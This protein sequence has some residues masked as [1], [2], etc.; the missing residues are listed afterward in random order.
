MPPVSTGD[1]IAP[2][3]GESTTRAPPKP[4]GRI[5]L[6]RKSPPAPADNSAQGALRDEYSIPNP[7]QSAQ[8]GQAAPLPPAGDDDEQQARTEPATANEAPAAA[9]PNLPPA[10]P[11]ALQPKK[12]SRTRALAAAPVPNRSPYNLRSRRGA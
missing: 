11:N 7:E 9:A 6:K 2:A 5:V 1:D 4:P 10:Q 3:D 12:R 8:A